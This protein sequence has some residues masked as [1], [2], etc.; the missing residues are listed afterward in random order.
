MKVSI[1]VPEP[2]A[3]QLRQRWSDLP[4]KA[5]EVLVIDAYREGIVSAP[6]VQELLG[7]SS[8]WELDGFL[9]QAAVLL[10]YDEEDLENDARV[11]DELLAE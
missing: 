9:K 3:S 7:F 8:R 2:I 1:E 6:Q 11:L 10:P 4:R 5:L